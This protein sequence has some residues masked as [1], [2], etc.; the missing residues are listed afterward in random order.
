MSNK[1]KFLFWTTLSF[2]F[3]VF[4]NS[5]PVKASSDV[6]SSDVAFEEEKII[7][8]EKTEGVFEKS[9]VLV[10][11]NLPESQKSQTRESE[12]SSRKNSE[13]KQPQKTCP[14]I[15][16]V[17][18]GDT[19]S[20]I[21]QK[22]G[23]KLNS[24]L[25]SNNLSENS[26]IKPG[27]KLK[28]PCEDGFYYTIK[29]GDTLSQIA[30]KFEVDLEKIKKANQIQG[31]KIYPDEVIFLPGAKRCYFPQRTSRRTL[32]SH[33]R[34]SLPES[35]KVQKRIHRPKI[36]GPCHRFPYGWCTYYVSLKRC[37]P[38]RGDA[39][40]WC[41]QARRY[42]FATGRTPRPGAIIVTRESWWGHVGYV[43]KVSGNMVLISEMNKVG[44]GKVSWRWI[45]NRSPIIKCYIY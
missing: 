11:L 44:W 22:F 35:K 29:E 17:K 12:S 33:L 1:P 37:I 30:K 2:I 5:L 31:E 43:E 13:K 28:I 41:W 15:Y 32:S 23:L 45:D 4:L 27:M 18:E 20:E 16:I 19:L 14:Q 21:A 8:S 24:V 34:S 10:S 36:K 3:F 9:D 6:F 38:W 40:T 39:G 42:G 25:C 26:L 7:T